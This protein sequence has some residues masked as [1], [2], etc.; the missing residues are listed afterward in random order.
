MKY[1]KCGINTTFMR[2]FRVQ[3]SS[4]ERNRNIYPDHSY[5]IKIRLNNIGYPYNS[6]YAHDFEV[7]AYLYDDEYYFVNNRRVYVKK[8]VDGDNEYIDFGIDIP[9][10]S[11]VAHVEIDTV[12][13]GSIT[14]LFDS[15]TKSEYTLIDPLT[16]NGIMMNC[17]FDQ[18]TNS[19]VTRTY[20][21]IKGLKR[22]TDGI[23]NVTAYVMGDGTIYNGDNQ[24]FTLTISSSDDYSQTLSVTCKR[25]CLLVTE[26]L[27]N[28]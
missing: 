21:T 14:W 7:K 28:A 4:K 12:N 9:Q 19:N 18:W 1:V 16:S 10:Y 27:V 24:S 17:V 26:S 11:S 5:A 15:A 2:L 22:I 20:K 6:L 3:V 25:P 13:E 23:N 8:T